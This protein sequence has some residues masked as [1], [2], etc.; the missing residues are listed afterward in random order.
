M[1]NKQVKSVLETNK[2]IRNASL[3][4]NGGKYNLHDKELNVIVGKSYNIYANEKNPVIFEQNPDLLRF[5]HGGKTEYSKDTHEKYGLDSENLMYYAHSNLKPSYKV[6]NYDGFKDYMSYMFDVYGV[7]ESYAGYLAG[8]L[9]VRDLA[10]NLAYDIVPDFKGKTAQDVINE[11]LQYSSVEYA[12]ERDRVGVVK[13][14]NVA[15]AVAGQVTTNINNYSGKESKMGL[16]SN[17]MYGTTLLKAANFNSLRR[18][19]YIT[20]DLNKLYGNNLNNVYSLSSLFR[21]NDGT[22]RIIDPVIDKFIGEVP[23]G[24]VFD[25]LLTVNLEFRLPDSGYDWSKYPNY[26]SENK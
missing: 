14:I 20:S 4:N 1:A 22:G 10:E 16:I 9:G 21:V 15:M 6:N 23:S 12:M 17:T 19:N 7:E 13:D 3:Q 8:L 25:Y 5:T 2:D 26:G 18:T 24:N 11:I